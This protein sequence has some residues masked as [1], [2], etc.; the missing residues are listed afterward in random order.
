[1]QRHIDSFKNEFANDFPKLKHFFKNDVSHV[2]S[3]SQALYLNFLKYFSRD[4]IWED[5]NYSLI[6]D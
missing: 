3:K 6:Q 1:M 2:N 5:P 4:I